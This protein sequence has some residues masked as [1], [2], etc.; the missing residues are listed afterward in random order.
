MFILRYV[1][2]IKETVRAYQEMEGSGDG[3]KKVMTE[4]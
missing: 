3:R 2:K 4:Q 1:P